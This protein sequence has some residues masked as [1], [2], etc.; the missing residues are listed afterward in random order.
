MKV[1]GQMYLQVKRNKKLLNPENEKRGTM[2]AY[3]TTS[4]ECN[5]ID[6]THFSSLRSLY[7]V[8][9]WVKRFIANCKVRIK[10]ERN[11]ERKLSFDEIAEV[12]HFWIK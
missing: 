7:R 1:P 9:G 6:P 4:A 10:A 2:K 8:T 3:A 11:Y 12:D 5:L